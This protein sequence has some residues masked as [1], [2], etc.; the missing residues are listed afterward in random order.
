[1]TIT[2][3]CG[4]EHPD[5]C[6]YFVNSPVSDGYYTLPSPDAAATTSGDAAS[7]GGTE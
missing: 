5:A 4:N 3:L 2:A 1:M 6:T 7:D